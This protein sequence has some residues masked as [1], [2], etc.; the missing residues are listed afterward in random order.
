[1]TVPT[2]SAEV[3]DEDEDLCSH[4]VPSLAHTCD[5]AGSSGLK[6]TLDTSNDDDQHECVTILEKSILDIAFSLEMRDLGESRRIRRSIKKKVISK[7]ENIV[8]M[9]ETNPP[10]LYEWNAQLLVIFIDFFRLKKMNI[11]YSR[12]VVFEVFLVVVIGGID[13]CGLGGG[14][15]YIGVGICCIGYG[16]G[17]L[18][19]GIGSIGGSG[20]CLGAL[21]GGIG[22]IS[23]IICGLSGISGGLGGP[24]VATGKNEVEESYKKG[25]GEGYIDPGEENKSEKEKEKDEQEEEKV[26]SDKK[27]ND[28]PDDNASTMGHELRSKS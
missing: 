27:D 6:P 8:A 25:G 12:W 13:I 15:S 1:M 19:M 24:S 28:Q 26:E 21:S 20:G 16:V 3:A 10:L 23:G 17:G 4:N 5:H 7:E 2:S 22:G 14:V 9:L 11:V 18:N